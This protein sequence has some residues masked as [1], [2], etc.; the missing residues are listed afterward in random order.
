M[1]DVKLT[2]LIDVEQLQELQDSFSDATGMAAISVDLEGNV[3]R[4]S[5]FNDF[6]MKYTRGCEKGLKRCLDCDLQGGKEANLTGKPSVYFCHAGLIDFAV[7]IIVGG[8]HVGSIIGGQVLASKPD[9]VKF[10]AIAEEFGIDPNQYITAL[11][12]IPIIPEHRIRSA[13]KLL[14]QIAQT[15]AENWSNTDELKKIYEKVI[16]YT[17]DVNN[18]L[19][20]FNDISESLNESQSELISE[21]NNINGLL[22]EIN[23]IVKSVSS[24]A[25]ETQMISFNAS[26]EAARAGEQGKS[27][28]VIAGEI[29]RLSEQSKKTVSNIQKFTANIQNSIVKTSE[30][31]KESMS[32]INDEVKELNQIKKNIENIKRVL[33]VLEKDDTNLIEQNDLAK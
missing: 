8:E 17:N 25:D 7:P 1:S 21:I 5:N 31:S 30:H 26:I 12:K 27:F 18:I 22:K 6:C 3:T 16:S 13:A 24:L 20:K 23:S 28:T 2:D 9:E 33:K 15:I 4:P 29:R 11:K 32:S 14:G 19:E 10:R